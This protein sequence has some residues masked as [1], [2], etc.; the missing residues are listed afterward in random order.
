M[1]TPVSRSSK[2]PVTVRQA[3]IELLRTHGLTTWFGNPGSS[4]LTLLEDFPS[5]F[6]YVLG[7]QEMVPVGMADAYAQITGRP[8]IVDWTPRGHGQCARRL[9]QRVHETRPLLIV[10]AGNQR[11]NMQNQM[12]LLTNVDATNVPKPFVQVG[13]RRRLRSEAP[14]VLALGTQIANTAPKA[15]GRS[16]F[17]RDMAVRATNRQSIDV[18]LSA[19]TVTQA[20][21]FPDDLAADIAGRLNTANRPAMIVGG[22]CS[23]LRPGRRDRARRTHPVRGVHRTADRTVRGSPRT[24]RSTTAHSRWVPGWIRRH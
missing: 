23:T 15:P 12:C 5:D 21:G 9:V 6:R 10:T 2:G 20:G 16:T 13:R 8:A 17:Q 18:V 4:E 7:L 14:V 22:E 1:T 24:I 19:W 3:T 11:R